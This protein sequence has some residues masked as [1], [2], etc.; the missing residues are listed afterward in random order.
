MLLISLHQYVGGLPRDQRN[1]DSAT[2][3]SKFQNILTPPVYII[4]LD[5]LKADSHAIESV[6]A[7]RN[8]QCWQKCFSVSLALASMFRK[9]LPNEFLQPSDGRIE[10]HN[11]WNGQS[12]YFQSRNGVMVC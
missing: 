8:G 3:L 5:M 11:D 7:R 10:V 6:V 9:D 12:S 4:S 2:K 1:S